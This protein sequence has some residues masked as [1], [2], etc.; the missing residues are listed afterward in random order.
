MS[1]SITVLGSSAWFATPE[2]ASAGYLVRTSNVAVW[3]D[4]G[5]GTFANLQRIIDHERVDAVVLSHRHPDHT[6]DVF[7]ACHARLYGPGSPMDPIP[8]YAPGET[9]E[10]LASFDDGIADGFSMREVDDGDEIDIG[11]VR[12]SFVRMVHPPVTLGTRIEADG[13][14]VA[15]TAD[16]GVGDEPDAKHLR[17]LASGVDLLIAEATH[18]ASDRSWPEGH[19]KAGEAGWWAAELD[20]ARL[21]LTHLPVGRNASASLEEARSFARGVPVELAEDLR[22]YEL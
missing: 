19:L 7:L 10:R 17:R 15:Y 14:S 8:I 11:D 13:A 3:L 22:T 6:V 1:L 5:G 16:T 9:I 20:A 21:V 4:A 18:Q 2:R 12:F